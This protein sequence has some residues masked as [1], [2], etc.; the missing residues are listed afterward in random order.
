MVEESHNSVCHNLKKLMSGPIAGL[1]LVA[2][3]FNHAEIFDIFFV[4]KERTKQTRRHHHPVETRIK[5][6]S[7]LEEFVGCIQESRESWSQ[8][9]KSGRATNK[10]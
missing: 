3:A 9:I 7:M 1:K 10:R 6:Q 4:I 5:L 8:T 2:I